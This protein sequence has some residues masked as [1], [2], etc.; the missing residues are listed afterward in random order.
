MSLELSVPDCSTPPPVD[1]ELDPERVER[2][3]AAMPLLNVGETG[4]K[5]QAMLQTYNRIDLLPDTRLALLE[6]YRVPIRHLVLELRRQYIGAS[7]PLAARQ[8]AAADQSRQF[9]IELAYGYKH[10]ALANSRLPGGRRRNAVES[11]LPLQRA[12]RYLTETLLASFLSYAPAPARLWREIHSLY[13]YAERFGMTAVDVPDGLA[14]DTHGSVARAYQHALLLDL[15]DPYHLPSPMIVKMDQYLDCYA[16]LATVR[17]S[18][19]RADTSCYFLIDLDSDRAGIF[20]GR[21]F[22]FE[23][24]ERYAGLDT[25]DLARRL[26]SQ[27]K[28]I[29]SGQ[30]PACRLPPDFYRNGGREL[31]RR[32]INVWGIN[33]KRTFRRNPRANTGVEVAV[34]IEGIG[35]WVNGGRGFLRSSERMGPFPP[36][37]EPVTPKTDVPE[38]TLW[39]IEDESA[40]GMSI[41]HTGPLSRR[42]SVGDLVSTRFTPDAPWTLNAVRWV[43]SPNPVHVEVGTE[44]LAPAA[45]PAAIKIVDETEGEFL[46]VLLLPPVPALKHPSTLIAPRGLFRPQRI[47]LLDD[48]M[49]LRRIVAVRLIEAAPGFERIE[50]IEAA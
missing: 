45:M 34:G 44:R 16:E 29:D 2:R 41:S 30:M 37:G 42:V 50:Y 46:N 27:L 8:Q 6:R 33:P 22:V 23:R 12:I 15:A 3:L 47:I 26:H 39:N 49:T 32:L 19:E 35:Y 11:A 17:R 24:A 21:D 13:T 14:A 25:V 4:A 1:V 5:L 10:V 18:A 36:D 20:H 43:R 31:L 48:G 9:G 7:L 28:Q 40:G 38:Y